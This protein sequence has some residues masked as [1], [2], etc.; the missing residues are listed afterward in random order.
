MAKA[1]PKEKQPKSYKVLLSTFKNWNFPE[2]GFKK[3]VIDHAVFVS[4]VYCKVCKRQSKNVLR[5]DRIRGAARK[6]LKTYMEGTNFVTKHN[7]YHFPN[8]IRANY[9]KT[10]ND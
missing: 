4:E 1:Q 8:T 2:I 3:E 5:D 10:L 6:S 7:V 9:Y